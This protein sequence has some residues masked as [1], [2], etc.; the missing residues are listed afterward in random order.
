M[1]S[2]SDTGSAPPG[3]TNSVSPAPNS[4]EHWAAVKPDE[5][6]IIDGETEV[7]WGAW[8][9][10]ANRLA[11]AF[12]RIGVVGGDVVAVRTQIRHEWQF[13]SSALAKL[14]ASI[15]PFNWRLTPGESRHILEDSGAKVLI[16]DDEDVQAF[17]P[18]YGGLNLKAVIAIGSQPPA[19]VLSMDQLLAQ[20]EP[21]PRFAMGRPPLII[22]TS[23]TT[24]QPKGVVMGELVMSAERM[25][26]IQSIEAADPQL[27][28]ARTM[29]TL[30]MHHGAG[31][32]ACWS[33]IAAGNTLIMAR[34]F[35]P[36]QALADIQRHRI[37]H[38]VAVPTMLKRIAALPEEVL[39]S[40]DV[41]SIRS[42][43]TGA[44]PVPTSLKEWVMDYFGEVLHEGYGA[45]EVGM[46]AHLGP[47]DVRRKPGS[48]GKPYRHVQIRIKDEIGTLL[49]AGEVG[50]IWVKS[51]AVIKRYV[52]QPLL[53]R[54]TIDEDG[55]FQVGDAGRLDEDGYIYL[56]DRIKD[57]IISGGVNIYPAEIESALIQHPAIQDVAVIG[58]PDEDL[59]EA[60]KAFVELRNGATST[61]NELLTFVEP[62]LASYKR[63]RSIEFVV[64]LPRSTMG[65]VLKRE[66]RNPFWQ[67]E[68]RNV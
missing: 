11:E 32:G 42:L 3:A 15:L 26:H 40:Y 27:P 6:A 19:E 24:G 65:K 7:T 68:E 37:N 39:Q 4:L 30:P 53:G 21:V 44:A 43:R 62:L 60:V 22:Y 34:R 8:N 52:N 10:E 64:D 18:A 66:L 47:H 25:E 50:A 5:V 12:V 36:Q 17:S 61:A 20:T 31:P 48:S 55:F 38:W 45:T 2:E 14:G 23:G 46:I 57:M 35:L 9:L 67:N 54:E 63:P 59:G 56:T 28:G 49:P 13:I 58:V 1:K 41:S 29:L 33:S 16:L 51:P